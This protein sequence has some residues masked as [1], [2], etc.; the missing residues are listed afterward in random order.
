[1][2]WIYT[3]TYR[4]FVFFII[5]FQFSLTVTAQNK[6]AIEVY[7]KA[8][9]AADEQKL[10]RA[11]ALMDEAIAI[12]ST[13]AEAYLKRG[14]FFDTFSQADQAL[15]YF[16]KAVSLSPDLPALVPAYQKL[17]QY[18]IQAGDYALTR[19]YLDHYIL[20]LKPNSAALK[21][22]KRQLEICQNGEKAILTPLKINPEVLSDTVNKQ[23]EQYFPSLTADGETLLFTTLI[24]GNNEDLYITNLKNGHWTEPVSISSNINSLGNEGAGSISGDGRTLVFTGCNRMDGYG[25]CDLYISQKIGDVWEKP[26]NL[27]VNINSPYRERQPSLS[28]DGQTLYFIS[29][30]LGGQGG[31]DVWSS[32]LQANG[33]WS[34]AQNL[35]KVINSQYDEA[36]PFIHANGHTLFFAS[37]GHEGIGG[38]DIFMSDSTAAGWQ[39]PQN[40][41]Y[42]INTA[43]NQVALVI[44]A[45]GKYAYYTKG[46]KNEGLSKLYRVA[47]PESLQQKIK[48]VN[49][50]K[51]TVTDAKTHKPLKATIELYD[52]KTNQVIAKLNADNVNGQYATTLPNGGEWGLYVSAEGYYYKSLSFDYSDK[53][54]AAGLVLNVSLDPLTTLSN[55]VL[56]NIYFETGK[57][58]LQDKSKTEL[59]KLVVFLQTNKTVKLEISGHTDDVGNDKQNL[60]LSQKRA[61][62]VVN[63]LSAAGIAVV[64]VKAIGYGKTRPVV[65]NTSDDNRR[66]NRRIEW[67]VM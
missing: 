63:Y 25:S 12:D 45:D 47:L 42:P 26:R 58:D 35:G 15:A 34:K 23:R 29:E 40:L 14:Q 36:S 48:A 18:H 39:S 24:G 46:F 44:T 11:T 4:F 31:D 52:L 30:R 56:N 53:H 50:L 55:G 8:I 66:L 33:Q 59:N 62:S 13:Y 1:M 41:G 22:A 67:R 32:T 27:G 10:D 61:Q 17:I 5:V 19:S 6:R 20:F 57:A 3:N 38:Y 28:A 43:D 49:A 9:R 65:P 51:G 2:Y 54:E 64:R 21:R 16:R 37:E 60:T 7:Q